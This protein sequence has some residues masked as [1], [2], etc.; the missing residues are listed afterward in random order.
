VA[1]TKTLQQFSDRVQFLADIRGQV[2]TDSVVDRHPQDDVFAMASDDYR[3]LRTELT[4][5]GYSEFLVAT[6]PAA[7]SLTAQATGESFSVQTS[8]AG[9]LSIQGVDVLDRGEWRALDNI[10]WQQ[11]RASVISQRSSSPEFWSELSMGSVA[12][13]VLTA[14][15]I[16]ILPRPNQALQHRIWYLP[17][18]T[19]ITGTTDLFLYGDASW[20][21]YHTATTAWKIAGIRDNDAKKRAEN[22]ERMRASAFATME[23]MRPK[24]QVGGRTQFR[25]R[26]YNS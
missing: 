17:E 12:T 6:S 5:L 16:A 26:N 10:G 21:D 19:A 8:P 20:W 7:L 18:F 3:L 25:D 14:G 23:E 11:R 13:T 22:L 15:T 1:F 24:R 4:R 9:A 2:G